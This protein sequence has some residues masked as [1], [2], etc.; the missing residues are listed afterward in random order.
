MSAACSPL[1]R[2]TLRA[3]PSADLA[4]KSRSSNRMMSRWTVPQQFEAFASDAAAEKLDSQEIDWS[5]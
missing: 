1:P 5:E 4:M 2:A 3:L